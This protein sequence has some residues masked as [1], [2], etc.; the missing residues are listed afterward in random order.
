MPALLPDLDQLLAFRHE[1]AIQRFQRDFPALADQGE[2]LFADVQRFLWLSRKH[3]FEQQARPGA[4]DLDFLLVMYEEMRDI[5]NMWH[6]FILYT[7]DYGEYCQRFYGEMMHHQ[8]DVATTRPQTPEQ[9]QADL[10]KF[11][12]Y[13]YDNLG[14]AVVRRWFVDLID[15]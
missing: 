3:E 2:V 4:E 8:P 5:D 10:S 1:R 13:A 15:P 14:E 12:S 11:L 9:F 6:A 7:K